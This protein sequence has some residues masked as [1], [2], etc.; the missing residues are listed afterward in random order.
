MTGDPDF[1][2]PDFELAVVD[3]EQKFTP[4]WQRALTRLAQLSPER[5]IRAVS[6][7]VSP[8]TYTASTIGHL[9]IAGGNVS[10][11]TLVRGA[12]SVSCP[13]SGF[14]PMAGKDSVVITYTVAPT[15]N[16]I[17]SARA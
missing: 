14:I 11:V 13:V 9:L 7:G 6:P 3:K 5:K 8:F 2:L 4:A 10:A 12:N 15:L 17:P 1:G 16:F